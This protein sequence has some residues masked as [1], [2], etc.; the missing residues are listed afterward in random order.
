MPRRRPA[1]ERT[2]PRR[3][4]AI[5]RERIEQA[6]LE[7]QFARELA[8]QSIAEARRLRAMLEAQRA[9]LRRYIREK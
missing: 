2:P 8:E 5:D 9:E 1:K 3:S 6:L 4:S 7:A